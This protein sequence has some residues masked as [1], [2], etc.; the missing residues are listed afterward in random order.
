M[1][2]GNASGYCQRERE[3][4]K[5]QSLR[6][7]AYSIGTGDP[8]RLVPYPLEPLTSRAGG[9]DGG[10]RGGGRRGGTGKRG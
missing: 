1:G 10:R 9:V 4:F 2:S 6:V 7:S 3:F 8:E 5:E